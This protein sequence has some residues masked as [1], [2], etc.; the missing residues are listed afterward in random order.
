MSIRLVFLGTGS[1]K[2]M[3][4]RGVS[5]VALM[6][7]GELFLFDCGEGTQIQIARA[8]TIRPGSLT[9]VFVTHFHGDHVN[10]LPGMLGSLTLNQHEDVVHVTGPRGLRQWFETMRDLNILWPGYPVRL[11]EVEGPGV[12]FEREEFRVEVARLRH[13]VTTWGYALVESERPGRFDLEAAQALDIPPGPMYGRLQRGE[14]VTLDD[15]RTIRPEDVLGPARPG[16]KIAYCTDTAPCAGARE[17]AEGADVLIH[18]STYLPGEERLAHRR[19]H[20]TAGD[21]A[22]L[23][24]EAGVGRLVLTHISQRYPNT[25]EMARRAREI[26]DETVA[27]HDLMEIEV[28]RS[29]V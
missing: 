3:P 28:H 8:A 5:G 13:R 17:L 12:L 14:E 29:D 16:L 27:A 9:N 21:A 1:G 23:A 19:G 15:G 7:E 24:V 25:D 10:G 26:F 20:S 6:R 11:H 2:P 18:E 22:R 4:H